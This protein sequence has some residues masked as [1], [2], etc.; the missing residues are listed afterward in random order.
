MRQWMCLWLF[1]TFSFPI[2]AGEALAEPTFRT[3]DVQKILLDRGYDPGPVDGILGERTRRA[4]RGFQRAQNLPVTGRPDRRTRA[5][6]DQLIPATAVT[7]N[8]RPPQRS[9]LSAPTLTESPRPV[10]AVTTLQY[11][12][13]R[14]GAPEMRIAAASRAKGE[15]LSLA[16]LVPSDHTGMFKHSQHFIGMFRL[17]H[18]TASI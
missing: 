15:T 8:Q 3:Q 7:E 17:R 10:I 16:V 11:R 12:P 18:N 2:T 14:R 1:L 13:P 5:A 4:L 9:P 6:L